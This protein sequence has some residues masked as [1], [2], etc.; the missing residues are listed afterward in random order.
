MTRFRP[1]TAPKSQAA[2]TIP[3]A[4]TGHERAGSDIVFFLAF[5]PPW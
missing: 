1:D 3:S 5:S 4:S 2:M